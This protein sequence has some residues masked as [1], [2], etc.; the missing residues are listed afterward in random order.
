MASTAAGKQRIPKVAKV[1]AG[2]RRARLPGAAPGGPAPLR[3]AGGAPRGLRCSPRPRA[4]TRPLPRKLV[5][6]S[7]PGPGRRWGPA[8]R[9]GQDRPQEATGAR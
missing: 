3:P 7:R 9:G 1:R 6:S 5:L 2:G 4:G 8:R